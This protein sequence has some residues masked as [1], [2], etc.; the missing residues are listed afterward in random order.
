MLQI[1]NQLSSSSSR[2]ARSPTFASRAASLLRADFA[3]CTPQA[4]P[5][6]AMN[7]ETAQHYVPGVAHRFSSVAYDAKRKFPFSGSF[8]NWC[9][10]RRLKCGREKSS[11][12]RT[13]KTVRAKQLSCKCFNA[14]MRR[15]AEILVNGAVLLADTAILWRERIGVAA[16]K[17]R[18]FNSSVLEPDGLSCRTNRRRSAAWCEFCG[19]CPVLSGISHNFTQ[20][21]ATL[22]GEEGMNLSGGQRQIIGLARRSIANPEL[23]LLDE[24]TAAMDK[25]TEAETLALLDRLRRHGNCDDN[26]PLAAALYADRHYRM[27]KGIINE[28]IY[29]NASVPRPKHRLKISSRRVFPAQ[30]RRRVPGGISAEDV[31]VFS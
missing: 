21:Y 30:H 25:T 13:A 17:R 28:S 20:I 5:E 6:F 31:S 19:K 8:V 4:P 3:Y 26:A 12:L 27:E 29:T 18:N 22:V 9:R 14:F 11:P 1:A 7:E 16:A 15:S 2:L 23:L 24:A 10:M